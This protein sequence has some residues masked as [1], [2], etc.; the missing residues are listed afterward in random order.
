MWS[1]FYNLFC[2]VARIRAQGLGARGVRL[3]LAYARIRLK[4]G[5]LRWTGQDRKSENFLGFHVEFPNY[6][7]FVYLVEEIFVQAIYQFKARNNRPLIY[8]CGSNIGISVLY[9]KWLY[10]DSRVVAFEPGRETFTFLR[11]NVELNELT[12]VELHN[13]ALSDHSDS[14]P[15]H[16]S[17]TASVS[18]SLISERQTKSSQ[19]EVVQCSML[20]S[21]L[22]EPLDF[23]KMD[24]EGAEIL[25]IP[26]LVRSGKF[27]QI[28]QMAI[29]CHHNVI[30]KKNVLTSILVPLEA[31]QYTYHVSSHVRLPLIQKTGQDVMVYADRDLSSLGN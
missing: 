14:V 3:F 15:F 30:P 8:D 23:L 16:S 11:K 31:N 29:E 1:D 4:N 17:N 9:F 13:V 10:P 7:G 19:M 22:N 12:D 2:S 21:Y 26:E 18:A 20:S 25:C 27:R 28:S 6:R 5:I 24:I